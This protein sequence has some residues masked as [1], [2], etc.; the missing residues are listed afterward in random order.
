[1]L[2]SERINKLGFKPKTD[3]KE[4]LVKTYQEYIKTYKD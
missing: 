4:G 2:D 1:M 3:F